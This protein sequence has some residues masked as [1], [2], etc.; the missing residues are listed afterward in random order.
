MPVG[1]RPTKLNTL[2]VEAEYATVTPERLFEY[3]T[4]PALLT[5]WWPQE[6]DI[7]G[8]VGGAYHLGWS[9]MGWHLRGQYTDFEPG[10]RLGFSWRWDHDPAEEPTR[11]VSIT[12]EPSRAG[13]TMTVTHG[14]YDDTPHDQE[15]RNEHHL[16]GWLHFLG[17]LEQKI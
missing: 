9:A 15:I 11:Q 10:R 14:P 3:W 5:L 2:V 13:T 6:A 17:Q 7:D 12:F 1:Q 16:V 8:R 4:Q